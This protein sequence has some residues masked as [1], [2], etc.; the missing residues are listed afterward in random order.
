[1][2]DGEQPPCPEELLGSGAGEGFSQ[3]LL[4]QIFLQGAVV[5]SVARF[6]FDLKSVTFRPIY[7]VSYKISLFTFL[8]QH[9]LGHLSL[10]ENAL[11]KSPH[12]NNHF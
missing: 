12:F 6:R 9:F 11:N 4:D 3:D 10:I 7:F 8:S 1:M 5:Q 2:P